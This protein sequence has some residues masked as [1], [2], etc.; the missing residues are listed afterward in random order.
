MAVL[1]LLSALEVFQALQHT[2][3]YFMFVCNNFNYNN[4]NNNTMAVLHAGR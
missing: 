4:N 2:A 1:V 3:L